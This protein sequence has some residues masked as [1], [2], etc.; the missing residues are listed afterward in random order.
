MQACRHLT[1]WADEQTPAS[2]TCMQPAERTLLQTK[3]ALAEPVQAGQTSVVPK[4][5]DTML[6]RSTGYK[7]SLQKETKQAGHLLQGPAAAAS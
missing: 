2:M 6:A 3:G 4:W 7:G 5:P 1:A